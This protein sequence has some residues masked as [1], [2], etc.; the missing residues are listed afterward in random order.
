MT[1]PLLSFVFIV[2][3]G[4]GGPSRAGEGHVKKPEEGGRGVGRGQG[5]P[6]TR[7]SGVLSI[8]LEMMFVL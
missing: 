8:L 6:G 4:V 3:P 5:G 1:G 7:R 2:H